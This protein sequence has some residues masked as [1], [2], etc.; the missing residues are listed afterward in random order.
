LTEHYPPAIRR[1][2]GE[3][4]AHAVAR[5]A[6]QRLGKPPFAVVERNPV[7][8]ELEERV[9]INK[10]VALFGRK[11]SPLLVAKIPEMVGAA[12]REDDG[13]AVGTPDRV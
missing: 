9:T 5:R 11:K 3:V 13:L 6:R 12:A 2:S 7:Q 8:V 4:V 1:E 10:L